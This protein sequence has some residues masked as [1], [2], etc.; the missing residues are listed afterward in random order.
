M[1]LL[2]LANVWK[3]EASRLAVCEMN[4]IELIGNVIGK[5]EVVD[6]ANKIANFRVE[7]PEGKSRF[8]CIAR[9][10]NA[11]WVAENLKNGYPVCVIGKVK[12]FHRKVKDAVVVRHEKE[13]PLI[14]QVFDIAVEQIKL[15]DTD[16]II[17]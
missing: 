4:K 10:E 9:N 17:Q 1:K 5:I 8:R 7:D 11:E 12:T 6:G 14:Q 3:E 16:E 13:A 2:I 15:A